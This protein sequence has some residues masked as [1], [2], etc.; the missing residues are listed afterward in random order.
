METLDLHGTRHGDVEREVIRFVERCWG[1]G[2][3]EAKIITGHSLPMQKIVLDILDEYQA[4]A[5]IGGPLG[6]DNTLIRVLF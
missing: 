5:Q 3:E 4:V 6:V 2:E 1:K